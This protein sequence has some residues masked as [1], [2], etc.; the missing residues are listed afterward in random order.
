M[1]LIGYRYLVASGKGALV[2]FVT[3]H[4]MCSFD[5]VNNKMINIAC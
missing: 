5:D 4:S 3:F 1:S 2:E